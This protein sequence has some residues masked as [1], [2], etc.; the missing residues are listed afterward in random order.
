MT[1]QLTLRERY[2]NIRKAIKKNNEKSLRTKKP[3]NGY[4][5]TGYDSNGLDG[6]YYLQH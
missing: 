4:E 1:K 3:K 6:K 5:F 2:E